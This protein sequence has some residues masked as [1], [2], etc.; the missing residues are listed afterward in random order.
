MALDKNAELLGDV[1][2]FRGLA[3]GQLSAIIAKGRK[4]F[5]EVG[6]TIVKRRAKG[7]TAYLLLSGSAVTRP[8]KGARIEAESLEAG[9]LIGEMV[10]LTETAYGLDIIA[11]QRV[12]ALSIDRDDLFAVMEADPAIAHKLAEKITERLIFL[13]RDLREADARFA[14]LEA[15]IDDAMAQAR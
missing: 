12:R 7:Q 4:T 10:M 3:P 15:S 9:V 6:A 1:P 13:A 11:E 8:P 5:F 14:M 2:L